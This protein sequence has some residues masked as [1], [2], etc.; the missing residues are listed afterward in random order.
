MIPTATGCGSGKLRRPKRRSFVLQTLHAG[1]YP[2][3]DAS[4]FVDANPMK[5]RTLQIIAGALLAGVIFFAAIAFVMSPREETAADSLP[6]PVITYGALAFLAVLAVVRSVLPS[7]MAKAQ[8]RRIARGTWTP[9]ASQAGRNPSP[10]TI[11]AAYPSDADKLFTVLQTTSILGWALLEG[12]AFMGCMA[13]MVEHNPLA[14]IVVAA[15]V[16]A[17]MATFPTPGR[18]A[19]SLERM[20]YD[21]ETMRKTGIE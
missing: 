11:A 20:Q 21:L 15:P 6:M 3:K 8:I 12:P 5:V 14:L 10:E 9:S 17:M 19:S 4:G 13:Y 16:L 18:V 7:R 2:M 1:F